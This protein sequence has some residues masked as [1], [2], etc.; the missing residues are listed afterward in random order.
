MMTAFNMTSEYGML[1]SRTYLLTIFSI[2]NTDNSTYA[3][4]PST[5]TRTSSAPGIHMFAV[6]DSAGA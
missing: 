1:S 4:T 2:G 3:I 6:D 5:T